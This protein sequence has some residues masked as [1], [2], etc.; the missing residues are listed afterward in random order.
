M[1]E[2]FASILT[3]NEKMMFGVMKDTVHLC[4]TD[5]YTYFQYKQKLIETASHLKHS[6]L[7]REVH[8]L[9]DKNPFNK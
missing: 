8:T 2:R 3:E 1:D 7:M 9:L 5:L 4:K 6:D